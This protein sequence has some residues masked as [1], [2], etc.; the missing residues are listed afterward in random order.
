MVAASLMM[1]VLARSSPEEISLTA[2]VVIG[3]LLLG[4]VSTGLACVWNFRIIAEWG[5]TAAST[6]AYITARGRSAWCVGA[7]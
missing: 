4:I 3:M 2:P 1:L 6:V 7:R 5:A